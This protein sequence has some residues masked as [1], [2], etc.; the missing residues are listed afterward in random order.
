M[1][2]E[3]SVGQGE[4]CVCGGAGQ[5]VTTRNSRS[6]PRSD[7][8]AMGRRKRAIRLVAWFIQPVNRNS[9]TNH[10][11]INSLA[12]GWSGQLRNLG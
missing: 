2:L 3:S 12:S 7:N 9:K 1:N 5:G 8:A 4:V 6:I 11:C 10:I